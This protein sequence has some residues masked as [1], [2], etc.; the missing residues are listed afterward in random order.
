MK[1]TIKKVD[2]L[3]PYHNNPRINDGAVKHV[4][5]S[6][7]EFGFKNPI[8]IDKN[9]VIVNGHSRLKAALKLGLKEVPT[10]SADDLTPAQV[11]AL[12]IADN[13]SASFSIFDFPLLETELKELEELDFDYDFGFG[14]DIMGSGFEDDETYTKKV[15]APIYEPTEDKPDVKDLFD[16]EKENEL[17]EE[18]KKADISEDDKKILL[19]AAQRHCVFNYSKIAEYYAHSDKTVQDLMEKS[20]LIIIDFKKAIE[21]GYVKLSEEIAEQYL[22][23]YPSE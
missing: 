15:D 18:I 6:I 12:R 13:Q 14:D 8:L 9:N 23:D 7:A 20:A 4:A 11:K 17:L 16:S 2:D 22:K 10:I 1:I 3:I 21:Y 5:S 19:K